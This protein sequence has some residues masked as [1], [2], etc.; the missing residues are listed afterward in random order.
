MA[1]A[2]NENRARHGGAR[3]NLGAQGSR[4]A[5]RTNPLRGRVFCEI[6]GRRLSGTHQKGSNWYRCQFIDSRS[7]GAAAITAHPKSLQVKEA[8]IQ[9]AVLDVLARRV[10]PTRAS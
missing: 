10:Y 1:A 7:T 3:K 5:K 2:T 4:S 9:E 8:P 6:C